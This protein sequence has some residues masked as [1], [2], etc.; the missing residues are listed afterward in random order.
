MLTGG[1][2]AAIVALVVM[3]ICVLS[4]LNMFSDLASMGLG[5]WLD[6]FFATITAQKV[7]FFI[8]VVVFIIGVYCYFAGKAK[9]KKAGEETSFVPAGIAKYFRD[10]KGEFKKI[11]WPTFK[12]VVRNTGVTLA[13]CAMLGLA[14]CLVDFGLGALI[15]LLLSIGG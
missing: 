5:A 10:T 11:T 13:V 1:F 2:I 6:Y 3:L 12:T 9:A 15:D 14:V 7:C 4:N 8:A